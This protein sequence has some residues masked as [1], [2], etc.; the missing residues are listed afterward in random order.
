MHSTACRCAVPSPAI[1]PRSPFTNTTFQETDRQEVG[2][3]PHLSLTWR[4]WLLYVPCQGTNEVQILNR[5]SMETVKSVP[6]ACAGVVKA[7]SYS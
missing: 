3:D 2:K 7:Q 1:V 5:F 4:N 6:G